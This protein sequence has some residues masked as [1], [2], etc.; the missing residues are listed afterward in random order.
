[1]SHLYK[2]GQLTLFLAI[3]V[4]QISGVCAAA[5][6]TYAGSLHADITNV[7]G[8]GLPVRIDLTPS[9]SPQPVITFRAKDG[10]V[11]ASCP[12]G[13]FEAFVY[14]YDWDIP[15]L[16]E[17][18]P[19]KVVPGDTAFLLANILEGSSGNRPLREFDKDGDL[20]IDRVELD[21]GTDPA[22]PADYPGAI[23]VSFDSPVLSKKADWYAGDLHVRSRYGGGEESVKDLIR[24][25][26]KAGLDFIAITDRNS[27]DS[28]KDPDFKS[29]KVVLLPGMEW[30]DDEHGIALV[31]GARTVPQKAE[32]LLDAQGL[33]YRIQNQGGIFA[34][35]HPCFP[36]APWKWGLSYLNAIEVWCQDWRSVPPITLDTLGP[37][38][39]RRDDEGKL[40]YSIS[41][42]ASTG[43][44]SANGQAA[45]FW[46]MEVERGVYASPIA[47][48]LSSS[49]KVP[50][51]H[52]VTF[53]YA[54]EKSAEGILDGLRR[55]RTCL[56]TG[57]DGPR[58]VFKADVL[59]DDKV[60]VG[61][62]DTIPVGVTT[63]FYVNVLGGAGA[64]VQVMCDSTPIRTLHI[65]ENNFVLRFER[66]PPRPAT[67]WARLIH[68]MDQE[69]LQ[70]GFG[71]LTLLALS[72]PIYARDMIILT[73]DMDPEDM[74][75][76]LRSENQTPVYVEPGTSADGNPI[77]R[78]PPK[79][80]E[81]PDTFVPPAGESVVE[82]Q[83][84]WKL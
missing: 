75:L 43:S 6:G 46:G 82:I 24:R 22:D 47:G 25:A 57:P 4:G 9:G 28:A 29:K 70:E 19:L 5:E 77:V 17:I 42:A 20:V 37:T 21:A 41:K 10:H 54:E 40:V 31:Y 39:R 60:D 78:T 1:M 73:E 84:Q 38:Y 55:G 69:M 83:P 51:G 76:K 30:G 66:K 33:V 3:S 7:V 8:I 44:M 74:W 50:L 71:T 48:S 62:G 36:H 49:P 13:S 61:V 12:T 53:V 56:S 59:A 11:E 2:L 26:E 79:K 35:A 67:Y 14:I 64:K 65:T 63:R 80:E 15:I 68:T 18:K 27:M 81:G 72:A 34:A 32:G 45:V 16:A 52:P 23:P 58:L